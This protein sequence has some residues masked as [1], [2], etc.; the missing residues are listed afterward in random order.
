MMSPAAAAKP[1][2]SALPLPRASWS[3]TRTSGRSSRATAIVS[4]IEWP[5]TI[6]TSS[7]NA[8]RCSSTCGR[9]A[10]SLSVGMT[11]L[12]VALVVIARCNVAKSGNDRMVPSA[13]ASLTLMGASSG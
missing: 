5:S 9:F 11:T 6:T 1:Q 8:G 3:T 4:S 7:T 13:I 10:A 2:A 12:I